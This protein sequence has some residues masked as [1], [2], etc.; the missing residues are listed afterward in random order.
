MKMTVLIIA[1]LLIVS[2]GKITYAHAAELKNA[3]CSESGNTS[4]L[5]YK[6]DQIAV[7]LKPPFNATQEKFLKVPKELYYDSL[8]DSIEH[9]LKKNFAGCLITRP[10]EQK[11]IFF[12]KFR[13]KEMED[14]DTLN[15]FIKLSYPFVERDKDS[16]GV[17]LI[18]AFRS[19]I[20]IENSIFLLEE[21]PVAIE[22]SPRRTD[23]TPAEQINY[24]LNWK[25]NPAYSS[26]FNIR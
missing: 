13:N 1:M 17:L 24:A 20:D 3:D 9:I 5:F 26:A 18:H 22:I 19:G 10:G 8:K 7:Y 23:K 14:K 21:F 16:S 2:F 12:Y 6:F 15:F 25:L 4:S 11:P